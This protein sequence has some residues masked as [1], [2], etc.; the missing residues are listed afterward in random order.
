M[1][2]KELKNKIAT[3]EA[4]RK[5]LFKKKKPIDAGLT[6]HYNAIEK[7]YEQLLAAAPD[8]LAVLL[9]PHRDS[10]VMLY[11]AR[12]A[13][14]IK[15]G[16]NFSGSWKV[17]G[18]PAMVISLGHHENVGRVLEIVTKVLPFY[19][20]IEGGV[21]FSIMENT[22]SKYG[23][24]TLSV[25]PVTLTARVIRTTYSRPSTLFE[26][27]LSDALKEIAEKYWYK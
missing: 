5:E 10:N 25:N 19:T 4:A 14:A 2:I 18:Q 6:R 15:N 24:Y 22:L 9:A 21:L 27:S 17:T 12:S 8:D 11:D 7:L 26:G 13:W 23:I 3:H 16:V 1:N 20:P